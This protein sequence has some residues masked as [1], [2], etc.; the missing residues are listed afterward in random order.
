[1]PRPLADVTETK[2]FSQRFQRRVLDASLMPHAHG[3][4]SML[5]TLLGRGARGGVD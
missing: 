1:M 3:S 4:R 2:S 5:Q